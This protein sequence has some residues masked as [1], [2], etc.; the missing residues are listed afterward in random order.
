M[1]G[2]P[3]P[4]PRREVRPAARPNNE[5]QNAFTCAAPEPSVE[6]GTVR[7][8]ARSEG[9]QLLQPGRHSGRQRLRARRSGGRAEPALP[10]VPCRHLNGDLTTARC[11]NSAIKYLYL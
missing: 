11:S 2:A 9:R 10:S 7:S 3:E 8:S 6:R 4:L 5:T 1:N